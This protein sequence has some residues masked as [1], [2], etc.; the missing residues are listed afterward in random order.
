MRRTIAAILER[1]KAELAPAT[2]IERNRAH[3]VDT[4]FPPQGCRQRANLI[5]LLLA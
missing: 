5:F 1:L 4:R 2:W 3:G